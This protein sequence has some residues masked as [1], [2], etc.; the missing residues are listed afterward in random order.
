VSATLA[1]DRRWCP[2]VKGRVTS[3]ALAGDRLFVGGEIGLGWNRALLVALDTR[4]GR[5]LPWRAPRVRGDSLLGDAPIADLAVRG[6]SLYVLGTF[7]RVGTAERVDL[8][9]LDTSTGRVLPWNP[10][11]P[12]ITVR[13]AD[14]PETTVEALEAGRSAIFV[15][16]WFDRIGGAKRQYLAALD[17]TTGRAT[18]WLP[19]HGR[20]E[21]DLGS[22]SLVVAN[23]RVY[24]GGHFRRIDGAPRAGFAAFDENTGDLLPWRPRWEADWAEAIAPSGKSVFAVGYVDEGDGHR[25]VSAFDTRTAARRPWVGAAPNGDVRAAAAA[26]S[27]LVLGG[28]FD[29]AAGVLRTNLVAIDLRTGEPTDWD[30]EPTA[31][32][33]SNVLSI[34]ATP[35]HVVI[36][37]EFTRAGGKRRD[38]LAVLD[39]RTGRAT[40]APP[41]GYYRPFAVLESVLYLSTDDSRIVAFDLESG[42]R[43][44]WEALVGGNIS[45]L[46]VGDSDVYAGVSLD[47]GRLDLCSI[48]A[49]SAEVTTWNAEIV[50]TWAAG[51]ITALTLG[52]SMLYVGGEFDTVGEVKRDGLAAFDIDSTELTGWRPKLSGYLDTVAATPTVVYAGGVS[53]LLALDAA[54]ARRELWSTTPLTAESE[55]SAILVAPPYVYVG[56]DGLV[57]LLPP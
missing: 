46:T 39:A 48:D 12:R 15:S 37:G 57:R 27:M 19:A 3:L 17:P 9:A 23:G 35:S 26:A 45:A 14:G 38:G 36:G 21:A 1:V 20:T 28:S 8:A 49:S 2:R 55:A 30:P 42:R 29:G 10:A 47:Y 33:P 51:E 31:D 34:A 6:R 5:Q 41:P 54:S 16:G 13:E 11:P 44:G 43:T 7:A 22:R 40:W 25:V 53:T 56:S 24:L 52:D 50:D 32:A 18:S 4:T